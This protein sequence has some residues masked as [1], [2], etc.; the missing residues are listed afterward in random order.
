MLNK[1]LVI[2]LLLAVSL[3]SRSFVP[4]KQPAQ[5]TLAAI[6]ATGKGAFALPDFQ[7]MFVP[8]T[9][10]LEIIIRGSITYLAIFALL[11]IVLKREAGSLAMSDLLVVVLLADAAQNSMAGEYKSITD[12]I[13]LVAVIIA[14]SHLLEL[15]GYYFPFIQRLVHPAPLPLVRNGIVLKANLRKELITIEELK[16]LLREQ[17]VSSLAEVKVAYLETNGHISVIPR[18]KK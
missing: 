13:L 3:A 2:A 11:R 8:E 7:Q 18:N 4:A 12:G 5:V 16:S 9:P 17:G 15:L 10:L 1:I 14:W 6:P